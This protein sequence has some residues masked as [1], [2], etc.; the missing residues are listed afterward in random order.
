MTP[1][2]TPTLTPT[3][4]LTLTRTL[5]LTLALTRCGAHCNVPEW[6]AEHC[7]APAMSGPGMCVCKK[8]NGEPRLL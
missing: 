7:L 4:T 8:Q 5:T 1:T 2:P 3:L 6:H